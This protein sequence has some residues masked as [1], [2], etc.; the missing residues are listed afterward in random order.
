MSYTNAQLLRRLVGDPG[1]PVYDVM[2]GDSATTVFYLSSP[3]IATDNVS[4]SV[5]GTAMNETTDYTLDRLSGR[6]AFVGIPASGTDNIAADYRSVAVPDDDITEACRI[7]GLTGSATADTGP[8]VALLR[9]A[10]QVCDWRASF[11][12]SA[13]DI[14]TDGQSIGRGKLADNWAARAAS[15][16]KSLATERTGVV[17]VPI[18]REDGY[19]ASLEVTSDEVFSTGVNPR[20][21]YYGVDGIDRLP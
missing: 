12:A 16:R 1:E 7:Y 21:R 10:A 20:R 19:N 9:A 5:G 13:A 17:T 8:A 2:S 15:I 11:Y 4:I 3:P 14:A 6:L 18:L